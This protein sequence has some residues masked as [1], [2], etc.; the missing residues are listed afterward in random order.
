MKVRTAVLLDTAW[1][2]TSIPALW[3]PGV[4]TDSSLPLFDPTL[5][6]GKSPSSVDASFGVCLKVLTWSQMSF[7]CQLIIQ[8]VG[9][10]V[11][12]GRWGEA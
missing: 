4:T 5:T 10:V 7:H 6:E 11:M 3:R 12:A 1:P 9:A 8:W 2:S